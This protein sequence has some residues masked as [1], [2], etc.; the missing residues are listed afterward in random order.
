MK[1][2]RYKWI[3]LALLWMAYFLLQGT[4]QIYG[5]TLPQIK[6][7]FGVDDMRMGVVA[8]MFF[9]CYAVT[10]PFAGLAADFLRR[11]WIIVAGTA[12]FAAGIFFASLASTVGLL[13]AT[14]GIL[15]GV[16]QSMVPTSSTSIIQQLH[17]ES[18]AT[19]LSIYQLGLYAGIMLCSVSAGYLGSLGPGGWRR[20]F[21][22]FGGI[23]LVWA[24]ALAFLLRDTPP[25][26]A[27]SS[28]AAARP[29][30]RDALMAM[31]SKPSAILMTLA[32]GLS[33][34]GDIGFRTWMP[35][36]LQRTI[37]GM[38]PASAAFHSVIWFYAGGFLGIMAGS[39]LSDAWKR[40]GNIG[41][42]LDCNM[43]GLVLC[44]PGVFAAVHPANGVVGVGLALAAYGFVHGFYDSN[45][46][47]SFYEV[48]TP[49]YRT[50][51]YGLFA[52]GA[53]A[54]GSFAPTALGF[55]GGTFSLR[56]AFSMLGVFYVAAAIVTA[57]ARIAFLKRDYERD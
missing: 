21:M 22:L 11:K 49:R 17:S 54:I 4:R 55:I 30:F 52:C 28:A 47:A 3:A 23:G 32:F 25:V 53:F 12:L 14:Y 19:A 27:A 33:N 29:S 2:S 7:D 26:A 34:F 38:T 43:I 40:R 57:I 6:T 15:N 36:F 51:A 5:A 48:V 42:R 24:V 39:R 44:A 18:R 46:I 56:A 13:M 9:L 50:G 41:A 1:D 8:S 20:A 10:V 45:F 35:T 31:F 16:G 37:D